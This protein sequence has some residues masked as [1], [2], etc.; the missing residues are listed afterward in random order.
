MAKKI[1]LLVGKIY[2]SLP[3]KKIVHAYI[4]FF[5]ENTTFF[6][7]TKR[8]YIIHRVKAPYNR[9]SPQKCAFKIKQIYFVVQK[10]YLQITLSILFD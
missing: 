7:K 4:H 5:T 2:R 1:S 10:Y 8:K 9:F 6:S 3:F